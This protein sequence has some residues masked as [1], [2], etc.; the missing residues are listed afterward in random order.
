MMDSKRTQER[1]NTMKLDAREARKAEVIEILKDA[2]DALSD[3]R[4]KAKKDGDILLSKKVTM[5]M[6]GIELAICWIEEDYIEKGE[7]DKG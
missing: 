6:M 7:K 2:D 5:Q 4:E 3:I 1:K